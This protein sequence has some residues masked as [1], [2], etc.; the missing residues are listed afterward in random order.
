MVIFH[1]YVSSP[2]GNGIYCNGVHQ[3]VRMLAEAD[4]GKAKIPVLRSVVVPPR[5][6]FRFT[7]HNLDTTAASFSGLVCLVFSPRSTMDI[8]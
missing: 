5:G 4:A 3:V 7:G 8:M 2:E 1:C 6:P